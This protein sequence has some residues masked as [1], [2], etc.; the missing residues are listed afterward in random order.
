[1]LTCDT[2]AVR[3]GDF[4]LKADLV[5]PTGGIKA[6]IGPSGGGKSTFLSLIAG[7]VEPDAGRILWNERCLNGLAPGKRPV[8]M[9]FQ[10]NNLFP[11]LDVMTNV[12]LGAD[13]TGRP[14][15]ALRSRAQD[16]LTRVGLAGFGARKPAA[17]SGGQQS[18]AAL[19]RVLLTNKPL[20]LMDEPFSALG[21][22][23]KDEMLDLVA[24]LLS[25]ATIL[26]VTHDPEDA[27]RIAPETVV[28]SDGFVSPAQPTSALLENPP[29]ALAAYLS[30][31]PH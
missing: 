24:E 4:T 25:G 16:A 5:L 28:V 15:A 8:A 22:A 7:F 18:R 19:A 23:L 9:L 6:V 26:M 1:M 29:P 13:P 17:L 27:R 3:R 21:P 11:H 14:D 30:A 10:D 2:V 20:V 12:C 31:K